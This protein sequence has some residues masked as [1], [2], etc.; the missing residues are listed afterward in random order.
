M[1]REAHKGYCFRWLVS[2]INKPPPINQP[3]PQNFPIFWEV[4]LQKVFVLI[5]LVGLSA[6]DLAEKVRKTFSKN[7]GLLI[8]AHF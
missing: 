2:P 7:G 1:V 3:L 6:P 5:V 4:E 8:G